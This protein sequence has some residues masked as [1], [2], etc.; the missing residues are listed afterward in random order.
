MHKHESNGS[1]ANKKKENERGKLSNFMINTN[2]S[3]VLL[4]EEKSNKI[5]SIKPIEVEN[6]SDYS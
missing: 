4:S 3:D 1:S 2:T 5:G 6:E